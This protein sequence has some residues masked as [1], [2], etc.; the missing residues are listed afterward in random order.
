MVAYAALGERLEPGELLA[1]GT[2]PG[3]CGVDLGLEGMGR[4]TNWVG[5]P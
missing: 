2:I 5:A 3:C 1:T 4:L